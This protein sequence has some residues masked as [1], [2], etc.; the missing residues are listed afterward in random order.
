LTLAI[1]LRLLLFVGYA[2]VDPWDDTLY[3]ELAQQPR[4]GN[5]GKELQRNVAMLERGQIHT[6]LTFVLRRGAYLP[7]AACQALLG[8]SELSSA[9]PSLL[10]SLATMLLTYRIGCLLAGRSTG[11]CAAALFACIPLDLVLSTRILS[12]AL[13]AYCPVGAG[14]CSGLCYHRSL[15]FGH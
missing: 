7:I 11:L 2:N 4:D 6:S 8:L 15:P 5:L 3:L 13:Q 12:D 10:R 1:A 14:L 9:L